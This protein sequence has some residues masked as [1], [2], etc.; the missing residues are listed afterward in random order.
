MEA[1]MI[2][3]YFFEVW[4]R[5]YQELET[6]EDQEERKRYERARDAADR[7]ADRY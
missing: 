4:M 1:D 3:A 6:L 7:A 5:E 2:R